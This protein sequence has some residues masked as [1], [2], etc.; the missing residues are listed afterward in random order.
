MQGEYTL[1]IPSNLPQDIPPLVI[2]QF[3]V[4][5]L[6][7]SPEI[8][9]P[10]AAL[11]YT[12][13]QV[14][15]VTGPK[16][17]RLTWTVACLLSPDDSLK[18]AALYRWQQTQLLN[19][20]PGQ[21]LWTDELIATDPAPVDQLPR[22]LVQAKITSY[23]YTYG[24]PQVFCLLSAIERQTVGQSLDLCSFLVNEVRLA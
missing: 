11:A 10:A 9:Q 7:T 5:Y 6:A 15:L 14:P 24:Y 4:E 17:D 12:P 2:N 13:A 20:Q 21:L 22:S 16:R 8:F 18:L 1:E 19:Q 3:P 23:G